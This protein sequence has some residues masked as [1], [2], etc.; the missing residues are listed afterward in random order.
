MRNLVFG[1]GYQGSQGDG[2]GR[3]VRMGDDLG[4]LSFAMSVHMELNHNDAS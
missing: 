1:L 2:L 4:M 3:F